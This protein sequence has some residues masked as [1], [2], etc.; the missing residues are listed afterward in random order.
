MNEKS[1]RDELF[2]EASWLA[3]TSALGCVV[4]GMAHE[5]N[6]IFGRILGFAELSMEEDVSE[7][8]KEFLTEV[9]DS[10]I[11]MT[12]LSR[13]LGRFSRRR[14]SSAKPIK[15]SAIIDKAKEVIGPEFKAESLKFEAEAE[16]DLA[17]LGDEVLLAQAITHPALVLFAANKEAKQIT[18]QVNGRD[19]ICELRLTTDAQVSK[20]QLS[21]KMK[22]CIPKGPGTH[23]TRPLKDI[24]ES[25]SL[26]IPRAIVQFHGGELTV[27]EKGLLLS[28][29]LAK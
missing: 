5:M 22:L 8:T 1:E 24:L 18:L 12:E 19:D 11:Q 4:G 23:K 14:A 27:E 17:I 20:E 6:N 15:V 7:E 16:G 13:W 28:F 29:P 3:R 21:E 2:E 25:Y 9:R 10:I 26:L